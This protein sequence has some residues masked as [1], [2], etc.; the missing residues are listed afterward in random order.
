MLQSFTY[1][2]PSQYIDAKLQLLD[3][4][5]PPIFVQ[6]YFYGLAAFPLILYGFFM[7]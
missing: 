1:E 6:T 4:I 7:L 2:A 5:A 3:K